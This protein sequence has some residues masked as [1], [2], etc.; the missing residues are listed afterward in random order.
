MTAADK[1]HE[2]VEVAESLFAT[3]PD[4][5]TFYREILGLGGI[6]RRKYRSIHALSKFEQTDAY[7]QIQQ[8]LTQLR[9]LPRAPTKEEEDEEAEEGQEVQVIREEEPTHVITVRIP[10][11]LHDALRLE[12]FEHRTS[13]NKLCISKLLQFIDNEMVPAA[14]LGGSD[15]VRDVDREKRP[16]VGL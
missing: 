14:S 2:I 6:V 7:R 8:M 9:K 10:K 5:V 1:Q 15:E 13:L 12:A 3:Q 11:S 16:G 4:W